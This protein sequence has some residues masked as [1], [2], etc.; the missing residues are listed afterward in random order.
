MRQTLIQ[1]IASTIDARQTCHK[2]GNDTW[3][4]NHGHTLSTLATLLPS[5]SG[6]D[7]GTSI[8]VENSTGERIVLGVDFHHMDENGGD[9]GWA[10][11]PF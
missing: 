4:V 10:Q 9:D 2:V 11:H 8:D 6:I 1:H 7:C 3:Y 5:G